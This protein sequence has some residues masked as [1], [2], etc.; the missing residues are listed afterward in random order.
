[1]LKVFLSKELTEIK[2]DKKLLFSTILL[3]F[4]LLPLIGIILY[5]SV[6]AQPPIIAVLNENPKN[7]PY[8]NLVTNYIRSN[9]G[10]VISNSTQADVVII[11]PN[12]FYENISNISRQAYVYFYVLIS[13]NQNAVDLA[14]SAL[15]KLLQNV[16]I[17]RIQYLSSLAHVNVS[18]SSVRDP[19]YLILGYKA[20][21]GK[22]VSAGVSELAS[23]A[24]II[25]LILFPSATPVVFYL[26]EGIT[27]ERER[28]T[29]ESILAT[30]L[31]IRSFILSKLFIAVALGIFSSLGDIIGTFLFVFLSSIAFNVTISLTLPFLIIIILVYMVSII[32][33]GALSLIF[34]YIFGGSTRNIQII[35]FIIISFGM[36]ASFVA[37]FINP[38]Q[39]AFPLALIYGIPYVQLSLGLL[40]YVFGLLQESIF[41]LLITL[42]VSVV[43]ILLI[44]R[45]FNPER[46]L[47]K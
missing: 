25:A 28:K 13:S 39:L 4:I 26:L 16:S 41:S 9:G 43:L 27:G 37:L 19:I 3:P 21:S 32:L 8:V 7:T 36:I 47:L 17:S 34:L 2:R 23:F 35:N 42:I 33:T 29:L 45:V 31:S 46:L 1:M 6:S 30:P 5:A 38:S 22:S 14:S 11:F 10:D 15:G 18:P 24:R 20:I 40:L 12:D 44:S